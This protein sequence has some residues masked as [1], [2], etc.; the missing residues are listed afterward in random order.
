[1]SRQGIGM[2]IS[3]D[4]TF[5]W[6]LESL[7]HASFTTE[8]TMF[9]GNL[10]KTQQGLPRWAPEYYGWDALPN[11]ALPNS[12]SPCDSF[13][14]W[15]CNMAFLEGST[16]WHV[17]SWTAAGA[18]HLQIHGRGWPLCGIWVCGTTRMSSSA[19]SG[20]AELVCPPRG[21]CF[22]CQVLL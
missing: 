21:T 2:F 4:G 12:F 14:C 1:M 5:P 3:Y 11:P 18:S 20:W 10:R 17:N 16:V 22:K 15:C 19:L 13:I 7:T 6:L 9:H 8:L